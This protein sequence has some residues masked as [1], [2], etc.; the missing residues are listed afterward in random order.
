LDNNLT[1]NKT[2]LAPTPSGFLHLGN[3]YSFIITAGLAKKSGAKIFLRID[4]ADRER[5]N[6]LYVQD[7]FDT[8]N[9]LGIPWHEGPRTV[10]EYEREYSQVHRMGMYNKA[11]QQL[12]EN[13]D[14]FA[15]RCSRT[16]VVVNGEDSVYPGTCRN[17]NLPFDAPNVSWRLR[18]NK[19]LILEV[20]TWPDKVVQATLPASMSEFIVRKK[21]GFPAYQL[22][23]VIDDVYFGIDLIVRGSDLWNS[24]L[25][26]LYLS[27]AIGEGTFK[28]TTF[29]HHKL[30][31]GADG[32]KLSKSA[33]DTSV[34]YLRKEGKT[35][36]DIFSLIADMLCI[37]GR[38]DNWEDLFILM[39][40]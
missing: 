5:T 35:P 1:F 12:R 19:E 23:S 30:L 39:E 8:L 33:A 4:D 9:F 22:T 10:H 3:I 38:F 31:S 6:K 34:Q 32:N 13:H 28:E 25:A 15:C 2:R 24:T 7:I 37:E 14:L 17:L 21:D 26:Q 40:I 18:T 36:A 16:Q 29:Y 11:L 27:S 20:K